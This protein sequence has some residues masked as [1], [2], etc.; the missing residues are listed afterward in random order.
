MMEGLGVK[1]GLV[2]QQVQE[3]DFLQIPDDII[4]E[5]ILWAIEWSLVHGNDW[6]LLTELSTL[7]ERLNRVIHAHVF[8][9]IRT[10][11]RE[12]L[13][14]RLLLM[15]RDLENLHLYDPF[16]VDTE[17]CLPLL[18]RFAHLHTLR[19]DYYH[20]LDS[21]ALLSLTRLRE[22]LLYDVEV[23]GR[24][25][26]LLPAGLERLSLYGTAGVE[27]TRLTNLRVLVLDTT[28]VPGDLSSLTQLEELVIG[29]LPYVQEETE[30][31][32]SGL[33]LLR[34]LDIVDSNLN[35]AFLA[36][37][38]RLQRLVTNTNVRSP[39]LRPLT[40]LTDLK[41]GRF[42]QID[43]RAV[44][45]Y[46][47]RLRRLKINPSAKAKDFTAQSLRRMTSLQE[48]QFDFSGFLM[49]DVELARMTNLTNLDLLMCK[50]VRAT[51]L[52]FLTR[53]RKLNLTFVASQLA[54]ELSVNPLAFG[55]LVNLTKLYTSGCAWFTDQDLSASFP[56]LRVLRYD[57]DSLIARRQLDLLMER[58]VKLQYDY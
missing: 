10:L 20:N 5:I 58:G 50:T 37:L 4:G 6:K 29:N 44:A 23:G 27:M 2:I 56:S 35:G 24:D 32:I 48:L 45:P 52:P 43:D 25:W 30:R 47:S 17:Y 19:V 13:E 22:L 46:A 33:P 53:L 40:G 8:P 49:A 34:A 18:S 11:F 12:S 31:K 15:F 7:S 54:P 28:L 55:T 41:I 26:I 36:T 51:S 3:A 14:A 1:R 42:C 38:P 16:E 57:D 21:D 39:D 9:R